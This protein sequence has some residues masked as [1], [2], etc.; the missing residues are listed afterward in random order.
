M[1]DDLLMF[2]VL[3][4][5]VRSIQI[6]LGLV[7]LFCAACNQ[8]KPT[9]LA[10]TEGLPK[11]HATDIAYGSFPASH[12]PNRQTKIGPEACVECHASVVAEWQASHHAQANRPISIE[13]DRAAFT[14]PRRIQ[15]SGVT[16]E[17]A[18]TD[19]KFE[20]RV[21]HEDGQVERYNLIGVI[22]YTPLRQY[23]AHLPGDKF[24][25]ISATYDVQ[26][27]RWIDVYSNENRLPGEWGH[28][29][30]QGMNWNAN[31]AYCHVTE[32]KKNFDFNANR[33][34]STWTQQGLAC[35]E[36]HTGLEAHVI[37]AQNGDYSS[38][39][40]ELTTLQTEHNCA[41]CHSRR[42]QL[43][44]DAFVSGDDFHDHFFLSLPDQ[45]NL[46]HPDG[47][48]LDEVFVYGSFQMSRMAH[49]GVSCKDCHDPHTLKT[50]LPIEN[51]LLCMRCHS[52]GVNNAPIIE[53]VTH[54]FHPANSTGNQCVNCHMSKTTYMQIDPRADHAFLSPDPLLTKELG[55]PN[56][57]NKCHTD[58]S[59][60]WA[61]EWA[62]QWYGEHMLNHPQ[63]TRARI[64]AAAHRYDPSALPG[65]LEQLR[66]ETVSGWRAT[67]TGLLDHYLPNETVVATLRNL[68]DDPSPMVR[69]RAATSLGNTNAR[70]AVI[71][72]LNDSSRS[73]RIA[74]VRG[75]VADQSIPSPLARSEWNDYL[76]FSIDRPQSLLMLAHQAK[77]EG[78][79]TDMHTYLDRAIEMDQLNPALYRQSAILL[80]AAGLPTAA[81]QTLYRGWEL[82]PTDP[83][84]PYSL[85][86]LAAEQQELER[87]IGFLEETVA[88]EPRFSRAW[89]NLSLAYAK[90]NRHEDAAQAMQR[91]RAA[92]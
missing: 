77:Q 2:A 90:L 62:E 86:L 22:G 63:R 74:A 33:Y 69:A 46:Y 61:V 87:A 73:V 71:E 27:D 88:L 75:I 47:Q 32:Y 40:S 4:T 49:A 76:E 53:P 20:L 21:L 18:E 60:D 79:H 80:S 56:A 36:C 28:W 6:L 83:V 67:Y 16:Y 42:D 82:A 30:N 25:T 17:M 81:E 43:T 26:Q 29:A 23:L 11:A 39:L 19:G 50:V 12:N 35:A 54:S 85:G 45:P 52:G 66:N 1:C 48:I 44:A 64:I 15:E 91:A 7:L 37:A 65:L 13:L 14:P 3:L 68:L 24:Q 10:N 59:V 89:Y 55:I 34:R 8:S 78:R 72:T 38:E 70:D 31:C 92:Y 5:P 57:C 58:Q 51:N 41:R 9:D 84:F